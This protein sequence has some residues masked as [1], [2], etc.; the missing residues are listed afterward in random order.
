MGRRFIRTTARS[1]RMLVGQSYT[2]YWVPGDEVRFSVPQRT[3]IHSPISV[4]LPESF[5]ALGEG[6]R[7]GLGVRRT[8]P[9]MSW[10]PPT[11]PPPPTDLRVAPA[12][13]LFLP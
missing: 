9:S 4:L 8:T 6:R 10:P 7:C 1:R 2:N 11:G 5:V 13:R 12:K 3:S